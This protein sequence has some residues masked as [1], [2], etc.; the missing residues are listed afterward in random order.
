MESVAPALPAGSI[1]YVWD[2]TDTPAAFATG[3][4]NLVSNF[5][6]NY[7]NTSALAGYALTEKTDLQVQYTYYRADNY[8]DD[9]QF[10]QPYGADAEEHGVTA[11]VIQRIRQNMIW[12][13]KYGFFNYRDATYGGRNDYDAHLVYSS[14]RYLF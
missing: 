11:S 1:N 10:T 2:Q 6:N 8:Q 13:V 12:T 3:S 14:L 7:W 5:E 4:T 9:S